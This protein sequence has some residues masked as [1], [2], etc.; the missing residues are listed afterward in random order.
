ME[1]HTGLSSTFPA[2]APSAWEGW[3]VWT[4][5]LGPCAAPELPIKRVTTRAGDDVGRVGK[6]T[7]AECSFADYQ[8]L[9]LS[10]VGLR[11]LTCLAGDFQILEVS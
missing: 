2:L 11:T 1:S 6:R 3:E 7:S 9:H 4:R 8:D 5:G 10:R